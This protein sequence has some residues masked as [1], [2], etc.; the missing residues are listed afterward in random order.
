MRRVRPFTAI[1][2]VLFPASWLA[3]NAHHWGP[4]PIYNWRA[5]ID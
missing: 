2:L 1:S 4:E 3:L 5:E